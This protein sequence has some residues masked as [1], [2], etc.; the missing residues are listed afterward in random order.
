MK[1]RI[2][3]AWLSLDTKWQVLLFLS[4]YILIVTVVIGFDRIDPSYMTNEYIEARITRKLYVSDSRT[5]GNRVSIIAEDSEGKSYSFS[6]NQ[7]YPK[8]VGDRVKIRIYR[9]RISGIE[10]YK[11]ES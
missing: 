5:G 8:G 1:D 3:K 11:L 2:K 9:K 10:T 6:R 4:P 7:T